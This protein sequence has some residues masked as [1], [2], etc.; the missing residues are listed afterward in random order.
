MRMDVES[1]S[2]QMNCAGWALKICLTHISLVL[3]VKIKLLALKSAR[4]F[5][6]LQFY[7]AGKFYYNLKD[8]FLITSFFR[9]KIYP[10]S[11]DRSN[12]T[13]VL[14]AFECMLRKK[15]SKKQ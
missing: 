1:S 7:S 15:I 10:L 4:K 13:E 14:R 12:E 2:V 9:L 8:D 11:I 6:N 5:L 3:M